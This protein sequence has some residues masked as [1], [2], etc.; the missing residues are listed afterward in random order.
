MPGD[1]PPD[2]RARESLRLDVL[3]TQLAV[4]RLPADAAL[5]GWAQEP[6]SFVTVSR[7]PHEL[8][9]TIE[10]R[11]VPETVAAERG[12]RLVRVDGPLPL[13]LVGVLSAITEPLAAARVPIFAIS[14][15]DTDYVLLKEFDLSRAVAAL[16]AAGHTVRT[17]AASSP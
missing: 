17:P 16:E 14:T 6:S 11:R 1:D 5:P 2:P 13:H 10:E 15:Y 4:C 9:I 3:P 12:Y 7:T 8:S